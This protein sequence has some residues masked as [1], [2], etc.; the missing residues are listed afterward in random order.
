M[1]DRDPTPRTSAPEN[2]VVKRRRA[3]SPVA[4]RETGRTWVTAEISNLSTH[5]CDLKL[6]SPLVTG[7]R[8]WVRLPSIEPW[9]A[10]IAW[11][12]DSLAGLSFEHPLHPAVSDFVVDRAMVSFSD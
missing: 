2:R 7:D 10:R 11:T 8:V 5:G 3:H 9:A 6:S 12:K 4:F 1:K